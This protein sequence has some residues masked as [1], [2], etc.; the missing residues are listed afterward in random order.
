LFWDT[1]HHDQFSRYLFQRHEGA[2]TRFSKDT[3]HK[4]VEEANLFI[5]AAHKCHAKVQAAAASAA[6]AAPAV[7]A[8]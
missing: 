7:A 2:D 1:Y 5:D 6:S 4:L 8:K 3:A